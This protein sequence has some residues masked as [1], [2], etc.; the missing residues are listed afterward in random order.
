VDQGEACYQRAVTKGLPIKQALQDQ[1]WGP[2]SC[3]VCDS[4][5]LILPCFRETRSKRGMQP[6][7]PAM[8]A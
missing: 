8:A 2:R 3:C 6:T 4:K 1:A 7:S 5:A